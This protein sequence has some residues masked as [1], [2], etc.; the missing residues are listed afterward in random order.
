MN[1]TT[2]Q[3]GVARNV[4]PD[5]CT[6]YLDIR[7]TPAYTHDEIVAMIRT[8]VESEVTVHSDRIIPV[9][10]STDEFIVEAC[11]TAALELIRRA[12]P[13]QV[14]GYTCRGFLL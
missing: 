2:I 5:H 9:C 4:I 8:A 6:I 7:S 13:P 3:G 11:L 12:L 14:T 10:T 1:V